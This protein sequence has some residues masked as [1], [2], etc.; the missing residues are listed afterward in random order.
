MAKGTNKGDLMWQTPYKEGRWWVNI[1]Y[2]GPYKAELVVKDANLDTQYS[3][4]VDLYYEDN[5]TVKQVMEYLRTA[6]DW[7]DRNDNV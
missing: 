3:E 4:I 7:I 5:P 6:F 1:Y 2:F